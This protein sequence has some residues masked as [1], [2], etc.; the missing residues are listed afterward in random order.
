MKK[1]TFTL[2][3]FLVILAILLVLGSLLHPSLVSLNENSQSTRC[4]NQLKKIGLGS[5]LWSEDNDDLTL[6]ASWFFKAEWGG[7]TRP[8]SLEPYTQ[9]SIRQD[10]SLYSCP[11]TSIEM[12]KG[13]WQKVNDPYS[14]WHKCPINNLSYGI[15]AYGS[16]YEHH[17]LGTQGE[18][19]YGI[20]EIWGPDLQ[21]WYNFGRT[22]LSQIP[23]PSKFIY[24]MDHEYYMVNDWSYTP[25][26]IPENTDYSTR[27][28]RRRGLPYGESNTISYDGS[29]KT[30]STELDL[31]WEKLFHL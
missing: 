13:T 11:S 25:H 26:L 17:N 15:N 21:Y 10:N 2:I 12:M 24:F 23:S 14:E 3:E 29:I 16:I 27:W 7:K 5:F 1:A 19:G 4:Q 18:A 6:G 20:A 8:T 28:H 9:T 31:G 22:R 30:Y